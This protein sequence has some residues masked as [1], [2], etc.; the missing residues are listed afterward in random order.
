MLSFECS[1]ILFDL[2]GVLVDSTPSVER[3]WR[4]WARE[5]GLDEEKVLGIAHGVRTVE[6]V[7]AM[8]PL[9]DPEAEARKLERREA[10]DHEGV[11]AMPGAMELVRALPADRWAVVTSGTR[12]LALS[13]LELAAIPLPNILIAADDVV[14]GKPH[15]EPYLKAA[16]RMAI[17]PQQCLVFEDAPAGIRSAQAGGMKVIGMASTFDPKSLQEADAVIQS[18]GQVSVRIARTTLFVRVSEAS[19]A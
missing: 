1:A 19:P 18:L 11:V 3:Q 9:L 8:A 4:T 6:V 17:Q 5:Q 14:C 10:E 15:P 13:R 16:E 12:A 2:D 7:R